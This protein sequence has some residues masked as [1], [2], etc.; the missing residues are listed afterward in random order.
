MLRLTPRRNRRIPNALAILG[1]LLLA[2]CVLAGAGPSVPGA[3]QQAA[4]QNDARNPGPATALDAGEAERLKTDTTVRHAAV[5]TAR[6]LR[7][8]LF[9]F[10]H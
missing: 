5:S 6:K 8:N 7:V 1:A 9:L 4:I 10:R 3:R 2:A